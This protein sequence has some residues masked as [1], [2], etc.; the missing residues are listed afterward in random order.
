M[1]EGGQI[2]PKLLLQNLLL[3]PKVDLK[4]KEMNKFDQM[5]TCLKITFFN[6]HQKCN[7]VEHSVLSMIYFGIIIVLNVVFEVIKLNKLQVSKEA[8]FFYN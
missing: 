7:A 3:G 4:T 2:L 8:K 5:S 6:K 1:E